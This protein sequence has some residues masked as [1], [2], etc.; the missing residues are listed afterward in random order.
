MIEGSGSGAGSGSIPLTNGSGF[1]FGSG[2]A[3]L[4][5]DWM[6]NL[7]KSPTW[8]HDGHELGDGEGLGLDEGLGL[9][10]VHPELGG[11]GHRVNPRKQVCKK[12]SQLAERPTSSTDICSHLS[13][14]RTV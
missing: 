14:T 3:T 11:E 8:R 5:K 1:G 9:A 2:S 4:A 10:E 7:S 6:T 13:C 12:S